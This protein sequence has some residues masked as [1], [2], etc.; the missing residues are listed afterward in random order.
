[1]F[2]KLFNRK[3]TNHPRTNINKRFNLI[4]RVGQGSMSK[5]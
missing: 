2:D 1:M 4:G 3:G 5:V